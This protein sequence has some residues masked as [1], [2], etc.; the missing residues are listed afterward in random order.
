MTNTFAR[1]Q[2]FCQAQKG[3]LTQKIGILYLTYPPKFD[4]VDS[5]RS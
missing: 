2:T 1:R 5:I 4:M 3:A